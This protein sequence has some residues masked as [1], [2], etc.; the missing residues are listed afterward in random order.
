MSRPAEACFAAKSS[1]ISTSKARP[2]ASNSSSTLPTPCPAY[3]S[4]ESY[5]TW[6]GATLWK[7]LGSNSANKLTTEVTED[8]EK[9]RESEREIQMGEWAIN[10]VTGQ[11]VDAAMKIH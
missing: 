4:T 8:T 3:Y 1:A 2:P 6:A 5:Q 9:E 10:D 7:H 11:I